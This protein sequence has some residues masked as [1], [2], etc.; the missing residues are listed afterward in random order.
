[1]G[2]E[3]FARS[4][5]QSFAHDETN[6][7]EILDQLNIADSI[8]RGVGII[9]TNEDY[10]FAPVAIDDYLPNTIIN[11]PEEFADRLITNISATSARQHLP[12]ML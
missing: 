3:D 6:R 1:L 10:R 9:R 8:T 2:A 5:I 4:K 7:P 11:N 12:S